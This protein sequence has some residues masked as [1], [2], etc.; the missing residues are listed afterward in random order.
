M[1]QAFNLCPD[2]VP[3]PPHVDEGKVLGVRLNEPVGSQS[4]IIESNTL[5]GSNFDS[6]QIQK[7][8][9]AKRLLIRMYLTEH[10]LIFSCLKSNEI[11]E[12][13]FPKNRRNSESGFYKVSLPVENGF[14]KVHACCKKSG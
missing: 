6:A 14:L 12:S 9:H 3:V 11:T 4:H 8:L 7:W 5:E 1:L 2:V 10:L 13:S